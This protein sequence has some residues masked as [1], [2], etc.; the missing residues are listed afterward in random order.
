VIEQIRQRLAIYKHREMAIE[1]RPRA[2]VLIP[3]YQRDGAVHIVVTMRSDRVQHHKGQISFPGG[4]HEIED[5]DL[6]AT[7]LREAEEE[8]GL[9]PAHVELIGRIDDHVT[10]S[11]FHV[12]AY[13]GAL[14]VARTPY[15]WRPHEEE[16]AAVIEVPLP[17]LLLP[18]TFVQEMVERD[19]APFL[20]E[21][22]RYG[23]TVIWGATARILRNFLEV[24]FEPAAAID[25][26]QP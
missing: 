11:G 25:G 4:S 18:D 12:S 3:L 6:A 1:D 23:E 16:V 22:Y 17:H 9:S 21:G 24:A 14:A 20:R 7:A 19:G 10:V 5:L 13:V 26:R 8:I 15:A 2:G